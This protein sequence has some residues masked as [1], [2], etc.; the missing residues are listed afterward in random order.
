MVAESCALACAIGGQ[1]PGEPCVPPAAGASSVSRVRKQDV[2]SHPVMHIIEEPG[3][4]RLRQGVTVCWSSE[5]PTAGDVRL[6]TRPEYVFSLATECR[7]APSAASL[8]WLS[9]L[10]LCRSVELAL[11]RT[12]T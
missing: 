4:I 9:F 3:A 8:L 5:D 11:R 12:S 1:L 2:I 6:S 10:T 7:E